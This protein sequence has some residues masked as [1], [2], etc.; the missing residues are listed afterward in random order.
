MGRGL[1][2]VCIAGLALVLAFFAG[3][4]YERASLVAKAAQAVVKQTN[5]ARAAE[6][7]AAVDV[8]HVD[9]KLVDSL[10]EANNE[11]TRI[12]ADLRSGNLRL[13]KRLASSSGPVAAGAGASDAA[14]QPGLQEQDAEFLVRL[15]GEADDVVRQLSACQS[16][17]QIDRRAVNGTADLQ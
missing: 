13:R 9:Q 15:A 7:T 3:A 14:A 10:Q 2:F 6:H 11:Q 17:I 8:N 16:I 12:I 5:T 1:V 4:S